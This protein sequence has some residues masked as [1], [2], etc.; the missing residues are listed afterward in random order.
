MGIA[1]GTAKVLLKEASRRPFKG[2]ILTLGRQDIWFSY[3]LLQKMAAEFDAKLS[4]PGDISLS[5][6]KRFATKG[7]ISDDCLFKS[8]GFSESKALDV[9]N[10]ESA[11]YI[12]DLNNAEVPKQLF[13][14]FDVIIDGGTIEHIFHIPNTLN[15][16]YKMLRQGGRIIHICPSSNHIDHGFYMF[17]PTLLWDFYETNKF[18]INNFQLFRHTPRHWVDP[19]EISDYQPGCLGRVS[20]GGL[21][22][23]MYGIICIA[24]KTKDSTGHVVPQQGDYPYSTWKAKHKLK[25]QRRQQSP[26]GLG[27]EIIAYY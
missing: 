18:D 25:G 11:H 12:F 16:I 10:Y 17:S 4:K 26:K 22:D 19:W 24:T 6:K 20:Y 2:R 7:Y 14:T 1:K 15:N 13:K 9:S 23:S 27:L 3:D 21:D 8:L 5:H